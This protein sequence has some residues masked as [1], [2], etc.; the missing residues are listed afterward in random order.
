M[1]VRG[2]R[3]RRE[4]QE[5]D[6]YLCRCHCPSEPW[7]R[8]LVPM[9]ANDLSTTP[10]SIRIR[11]DSLDA[12]D[13]ALATADA[14]QKLRGDLAVVEP[15]PWLKVLADKAVNR[16]TG[17]GLLD[18]VRTFS[19]DARRVAQERHRYIA[20]PVELPQGFDAA[21]RDAVAIVDKLAA[22]QKAFG[23]LAFRERALRPLIEAIRVQ[24]HA[25]TEL[26]HWALVRDHI[27]W[28]D[29]VSKTRTVWR[30][31]AE[32]LGA[33]TVA[34]PREHPTDLNT[35]LIE[36]PRALEDVS[37]GIQAIMP[38][39]VS[40]QALWFE[41]SR[42]GVIEQ[43]LR[44]AA[45]SA[46]LAGVRIEINRLALLFGDRTGR[47]GSFAREFF[48][49]TVGRDGIPADRVGALW[50]QLR[51]QID[52]LRQ[53]ARDFQVVFDTT[54]AI[55]FAG[56]PDWALRL[57]TQP[58][59]DHADNLIPND[60]RD[61]WDWAVASAYLKRIDEK[62]RLRH[63]A[64]QRVRLDA[65]LRKK[66]EQLVRERTFYELGRSMSGPIRA[67]LMMFATAVR[68][69]GKG[70]GKGASRY[71]RDAQLAMAQCYGAI[72]C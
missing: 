70:A 39:G 33:P 17:D 13:T 5:R 29:K 2:E 1:R 62:D 23:L 72:P 24:G 32:E 35:A 7:D 8:F 59:P 40:S 22:G 15:K 48:G 46:K 9:P 6:D 63:L 14:I 21:G 26:A 16:V 61:A 52:D 60:W 27:A 30:G 67:A 19:D 31:L 11:L 41:P 44:N 64:E 42:L 49:E 68:R 50:D 28:L 65:E 36:A 71:R 38:G 57:R 25:P 47:I 51:A 43:A 55:R 4:R 54:E 58:A 3:S 37:A 10:T 45:A 56:A 12:A 66:F 34:T 53:H 18:L 69:A 20:T